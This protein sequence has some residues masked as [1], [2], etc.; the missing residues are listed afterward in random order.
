[1][2][3]TQTF[4]RTI[5]FVG[6]IL[7]LAVQAATV[8]PAARAQTTQA[9]ELAVDTKD[10]DQDGLL[11]LFGGARLGGEIGLPVAAGDING[12]SRADVI[13]CAMYASSATGNRSNNGQVNFYISDGRDTGVIDARTNPPN[14]F[15]LVGAKSGDLLGTSVATGDVNGDGL[16]DVALGTSGDDGPDGSRFNAGAAHVVL[17]SRGFNLNGDLSAPGPLPGIITIYGQQQNGRLGIWIDVGDVDGDAMPDMIVGADQL[18]S[19][20]GGHVGGAYI[21]FGSV[22][23]PPVI[24]LASPPPGVRVT[25]VLG[26]S[27]EDHLGAAVQ[28]G[29]INNDGLGDLIIGAAIN[30]DSGTYVTPQDQSSG[31]ADAGASFGGRRPKCGEVYVIYGSRIWPAEI[32][33]RMP[34]A[35]LTHVIGAHEFDYL[36]S[37][38]HFAD[39]NGDGETDLIIGALRAQAPDKAATGAVY[40]IYG[41]AQNSIVGATIDLA[42]PG[43]SG[44]PISAIY[45]ADV[46]DC[47]GDS[48]RSFD[49]NKDGMS[50]LFIGSPEITFQLEG[51]PEPREEAGD[52]AIIFGRD[53]PLPPVVKLYDLPPDFRV[54]RLAGAH[55]EDE[56]SYRLAGGDVDGDGFVDYIANAMHGDGMNNAVIN[57][58]NVY[59]FSGKKL[60]SRLGMLPPEPEPA[61]ALTSATLSLGGQVVPRAQAGQTGLRVTVNGMGFRADTAISINGTDVIA[62]IPSDP[63]LAATQRTV[64]LDENPSIRN[65]VGPLAV[66]ARNTSPPSLPSNELTAG[67]LLGPEITSISAKRKSS[68]LVVLKIRGANFV[69]GS[70]VVATGPAGQIPIKSSSF[71]SSDSMTAK[72]RAS[73]AP[74]RGTQFGVRVVSPTQIASNELVVTAP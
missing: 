14:I 31:H 11:A 70:T 63:Q 16:A 64:E 17:G 67:T 68:G 38:L 59:I 10:L 74:A 30:R 9:I 22:N 57:A 52:T 2:N 25:R 18:N 15:T 71:N 40:V 72:I 29:D 36:G 60:S 61:P 73:A 27:E 20:A 45:G 49:I 1:M 43:A 47:A 41:T 39:I 34:P 53:V 24:D 54:F 46:L 5:I 66:R 28:V 58:G 35:T 44:L 21:I 26:V 56:M 51:D 23:L 8:P 13:F 55:E 4:L 69:D 7:A 62:R 32:D 33:L 42:D 6:L 65:S 3:R 48:V 12:D 37:Q 50:D 19:A